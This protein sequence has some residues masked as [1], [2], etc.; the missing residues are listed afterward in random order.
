M[1]F[2]SDENMLIKEPYW[3]REFLDISWK[4]C[5]SLVLFFKQK[6]N[7][8]TF[9]STLKQNRNYFPLIYWY[10]CITATR[11]STKV[12]MVTYRPTDRRTD[13]RMDRLSVSNC[14]QS[15]IEFWRPKCFSRLTPISIWI[16]S[17]ILQTRCNQ[18]FP[19]R[20]DRLICPFIRG[21]FTLEWLT[22]IIPFSM[23]TTKISQKSL[24]RCVHASL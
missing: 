21:V 7:K 11:Q 14:C 16:S 23:D 12:L 9:R 20:W 3:E 22:A 5:F 8:L 10:Y 4:T 13:K 18:N 24:F 19:L 2:I 15:G 17:L 1:G 6:I